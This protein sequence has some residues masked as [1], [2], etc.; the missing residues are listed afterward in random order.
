[1]SVVDELV[2]WVKKKPLLLIRFDED[3]S[4]SLHNSYQGFE[5]L[6]LTKRH[7]VFQSINLPTLCL[8]EVY[9][10]DAT[11]CC[12]L[13][14]AT[15]KTAVSTFESRLSIEKLRIVF[16]TS[17]QDMKALIS[18]ARMLRLL[19]ERLPE[20]GSITRLS[21]Q[22]SAHLIEILAENPDN[23]PALETAFSLLPG[24]RQVTDIHWGQENAIQAAMDA[25]GLRGNAVPT[26]VALRRGATSGLSFRGAY[27]YEDNVVHADASRLPGFNLISSD[28]TGRAEFQKGNERLV[29]YTANKLPL[30]QM[31]GVDLIYINETRGNIVMLQYKMLEECEPDGERR[32]WLFRPDQQL[33]DE[34]ARMK[35]PDFRDVAHDY[36]LDSNPFYFKFVKRKIE[37]NTHN[38][39]IVSLEHLK[40]LL[41]A[42]E[43]KGPKGGIRIS[44][45]ALDGMYLREDSMIGL[46]RSGYIGTH[47]A[48]TEAL[49]VLIKE[50]SE[51]NKAIVLAWQQEMQESIQ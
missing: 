50:A 39:F 10:D 20:E 37:S 26:R 24:L 3:Y 29:I 25:F 16:P 51:G 31:L 46:I 8:L 18:D 27:L 35:L 4:Q 22:L 42:P 23:Q 30:E 7:S 11:T 48:E 13:A 28:V 2:R 1:M 9:E 17:L 40:Q 49:E 43:S 47:R 41:V 19:E 36:R 21:P 32:D 38:A 5:R 45:N 15:R 33:Y 12:Y 14:T 6:T 34:V 44:Y